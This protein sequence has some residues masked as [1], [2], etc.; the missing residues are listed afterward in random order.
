MK[1]RYLLPQASGGLAAI[2]VS[3]G[4]VDFPFPH[5]TVSLGNLVPVAN[6]VGGAAAVSQSAD[7]LALVASLDRLRADAAENRRRHPADSQT[8]RPIAQFEREAGNYEH[9]EQLYG[10]LLESDAHEESVV[11]AP[12]RVHTTRKVTSLE[13][14]PHA[15]CATAKIESRSFTPGGR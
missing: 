2:D 14:E 11:A 15:H 1:G 8:L 13:R 6:A 12:S 10:V 3:T 4:A 5:Q 7:E 9:A